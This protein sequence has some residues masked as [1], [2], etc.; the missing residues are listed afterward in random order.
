MEPPAKKARTED[1]PGEAG[2]VVVPQPV[3]SISIEP[4][5]EPEELEFDDTTTGPKA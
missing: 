5:L 1:E 2:E 4:V 3:G